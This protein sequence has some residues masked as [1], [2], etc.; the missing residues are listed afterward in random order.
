MEKA[1]YC[2]KFHCASLCFYIALHLYCESALQVILHPEF[3]LMLHNAYNGFV[4]SLITFRIRHSQAKGMLNT[5]AYVCLSSATFLHYCMH[6]DIILGNGR[7][8][9]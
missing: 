3:Q 1:S 6:P 2:V 4:P 7:G 8:A 9:L 5:G